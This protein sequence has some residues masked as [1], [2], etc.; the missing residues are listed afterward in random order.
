MIISKNGKSM[1]CDFHEIIEKCEKCPFQD[2]PFYICEKGIQFMIEKKC[3]QVR[4]EKDG[5]N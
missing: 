3:I 5:K 2:K 4:S 1:I